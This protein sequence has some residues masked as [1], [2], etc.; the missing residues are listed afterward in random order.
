MRSVIRTLARPTFSFQPALLLPV[1]LTLIAIGLL[2]FSPIR[3]SHAWRVGEDHE[4]VLVGFYTNE[5]NETD[6]FRWSQ[7]RAALFLYGYRGVPAL[8]ELR[9]AAPRQPGVSHEQVTFSSQDGPLGITTV[10]PYWRRYHF[11]V[12]TNPIGETTLRW[13]TQPYVA[14]PDVRELGVVLSSVS[15]VPLADRPP[16]S[17]QTIT[18]SILPLL[19]WMV[20]IAWRWPPYWRDCA[21]CLALLPA[22]GLAWW[23]VTA[24][25]WLPMLPWPWWPV[26]PL[27]VL[28]MW[29]V[30]T[31]GWYLMWR[32]VHLWVASRPL[33]GWSGLAIAFASILVLR[34]GAS[35]WLFLPLAI[36]GVG[37]AWPL[38]TNQ[39]DVSSWP[40]GKLLVVI[41]GIALATRL[42]GLEQM[43]LALWRDEA[44]HGLLALQI[45]TEPTFRPIYVP[46][47]A[48]LPA[49]L[50]Y[51][52]APV[53]GMLGPNMW[54]V[55]LVSAV[56]GAL[57]PLALY[58]FAA[59]LIGRR[60]AMLG[61][62]LLAWASWSLSMS[63][64][65]FPA[66]LDH[67]LVLTAA[68][69]LWRGL[70]P[71][72]RGWWW[73]VAGAAA[74]GGLAV[75]TYHTGRLA[76]VALIVVVLIRLGRDPTRWRLV[77]SRLVLAA[78]LGALVIAPLVWYILNDSTGFN[79][80]VGIVSIF[81]A[82]DLYRHR[83]LDFLAENIVRYGLMWHVQGEANGR[84]HLPLVPMVDPV[85]GLLL[86]IGVGLAWR[87][88]RTSAVV[89]LALWLLYYLPGLLSF[90]APHAMRSLGTLAPAC[91]LAGWGLSRL[92]AG[93]QWRH[94]LIPA[95]LAA[96]L[97]V[98]LWVYFGQMPHDPRVYGK[99][100]RAE[101]VMA[102]LVRR[103]AAPHDAAQTV[104]V[105][106]PREWALSDT[107]RFLTAHLPLEQRP[108]I[109][110][111]TLDPDSDALVILPAF[112]NPDEVAAVLSALGPTAVEIVPT[113][114]IPANAEPLVRVF[115]RGAAARAVMRSP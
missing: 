97:A 39:E 73:Y 5:Q 62:A 67:L 18:W 66:T 64:W 98:N 7:P 54:S 14:L 13:E 12:P 83:P 29:P 85:V 65:A 82:S 9:L 24:E 55:R 19:A 22:V 6:L 90:N 68:G 89:L 112:A 59:P 41:T 108:R 109:W 2:C 63:R 23:P 71:V 88:R 78:L 107:V 100:D 50:F 26:V 51:L 74:L 72:R 20:G 30:L 76:P 3:T 93:A 86:L 79:Q 111:G 60:A 110:R 1:A 38:F 61:A 94:W 43:P 27:L 31:G 16:L 40:I 17:A 75:Y 44:R 21:A 58:W 99:F 52:M 115:A 91:A 8:V 4:P 33:V 49:L 11:L 92:A 56:A 45:W 32:P 80:R 87:A 35:V 102:Q 70:D 53:V 105:Y 114:T 47:F 101:T 106:L 77:W 48:D 28:V 37:V 10:A 15:Q 113:P 81:Q 46:G 34:A 25:Y 104:P 95:A 36:V 69:L 96:S 84:H 103:A 42:V 57:T